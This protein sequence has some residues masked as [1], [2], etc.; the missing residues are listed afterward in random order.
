MTLKTGD[1]IYMGTPEGVGPVQIGDRLK[2]YI[3]DKE[4][5]AF[6]IK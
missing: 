1:L 4:M 3:G 5:F 6:D 2:G